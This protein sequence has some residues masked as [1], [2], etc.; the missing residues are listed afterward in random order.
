MDRNKEEK[1]EKFDSRQD[2]CSQEMPV[3]IHFQKLTSIQI[4]IWSFICK[5]FNLSIKQGLK[6]EYDQ[7]SKFS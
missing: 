4:C 6:I 2:P 5:F 3:T 7:G 1:E